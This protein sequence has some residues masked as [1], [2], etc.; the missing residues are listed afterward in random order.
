M[1]ALVVTG[2]V[3]LFALLS[4]PSATAVNAQ[5]ANWTT[6]VAIRDLTGNSQVAAGQPLLAGHSYNVSMTIDVPNTAPA[7]FA[8]TLDSV[9]NPCNAQSSSCGSQYWYVNTP[10]YP[11]FNQAQFSPGQKTVS[12]AQAQGQLKM[13]ALFSLP[14]GVTVTQA[15]GLTLRLD[16]NSFPLIVINVVGGSSVGG[17]T[18]TVSDQVIQTYEATYSAKSNLITSGHIDSSY[19]TF[20]NGVLAQAQALAAAGLPD[21]ATTLLNVID[22]SSFPPPPNNSLATDLLAGVA[23]LAV[24]AVVAIVMFLRRGSKYGYAKSLASEIEKDLAALE[25]KAAQYDKALADR[26]KSDRVKLGEIE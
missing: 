1:R 19:S 13:S 23:V 11:G 8:V 3:V 15:A 5:S 21:K 10:G 26:L 16:Q 4:L 7:S 22:P 18:V 9:A 17:V 14:T 20:V 6:S 12:F 25:V 24:V 2:L